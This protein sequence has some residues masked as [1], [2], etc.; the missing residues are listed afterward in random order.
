[1]KKWIALFIVL[2][3]GSAANAQSINE[4]LSDKNFKTGMIRLYN[5]EYE[6]AIQ[7]FDRSLSYQPMNF[8]ARYYL[9]QAY[10]DSGYSKNALDEWENLLRLGGGGYQV[11]QK[12]NDLYFRLSIDRSYDYADP[13]V[14]SRFYDGVV[15]GMHKIIRPSFVIYDDKTDNMLVSSIKTRYVVEVDGAGRVIRQFGRKFG[16]FSSFKM[17]SGLCLYNDQ[18]FVADYLADQ[19]TV[20]DRN[21]KTLRKFG[22][23]GFSSSNIAGPMGLYVSPDEYLYIVDNG[24][25]RIQKF[26]LSGDWVQTIGEGELSRPTDIA[27]EGQ[28]LYVSDSLHSRVL[29]YDGFGNVLESIGD[30]GD[31][32]LVEPRGLALRDGKLYITDAKMGL[33]VYDTVSRTLEKFGLDEGK[34]NLPFDVC[35]DS[36]RLIYETDFNTEKIAIYTPLQLQYAN[37]GLQV[38]QIWLGKYPFN[39]LH[40]RVWDK[41]GRPVQNLKEE[42]IRIF[43]EGTEV[44]FIRLGPTYEYRK[45]MYVKL[46]FDKS[47]SMAEYHEDILE[48]L[49]AF[50]QKATGS[51]WVDL[52]VVNTNTESSGKIP[53]SQL[54]PVDYFKKQPYAGVSPVGLD[55]ALHTAM[56]EL[57]NINRNKAIILF[58]SG[59]L[60]ESTFRDYDADMLSTYAR[61]NAIPV[62]IVNFTDRNREVYARIAEETFGKYYTFRDLK[63]IFNLYQEIK[64]APPL[65]YIVSYEGMNL[66]GIKNFWVNLHVK[67]K[68]KELVGVDDTGYF[69]PEVFAQGSLFGSPKEVIPFQ[70]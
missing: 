39:L 38:S 14:F 52:V 10:L 60:N 4:I 40:L 50:L 9:G 36:K 8:K 51:D 30:N 58:T 26:S 49:N 28:I 5:R 70:E 33:F 23:R 22:A 27:G 2:F 43:E 21:G 66:R 13:Y 6:A 42:N 53:V 69:V 34:L 67:V 56:R 18:L 20:F 68:Y 32:R 44:P 29:A 15:N 41:T 37:L 11:K 63:E 19:I 46:V 61:Q 65:E 24:N 12:L 64:N 1:M 7:L 45:N 59:D 3:A 48:F 31:T 47:E 57:L 17:P 55:Q 54:W 25:D 35:L 16:D 62:Y